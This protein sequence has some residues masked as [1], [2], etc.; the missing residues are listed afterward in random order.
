MKNTKITELGFVNLQ[1][2][3]K[4]SGNS[5][6]ENW[7]KRRIISDPRI[8]GGQPVFN[9]TR[10]SVSLISGRLNHGLEQEVREDYEYLN[11]ED[12]KFAR[13]YR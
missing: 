8:L 13:Q 5:P 12:I 9:G 10:L 7:K 1:I 11:D 6:F 3:P 4:N 2:E